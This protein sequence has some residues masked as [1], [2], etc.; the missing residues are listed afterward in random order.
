MTTPTQKK[1]LSN[2]IFLVIIIVA[3]GAVLSLGKNNF[4]VPAD[5]Q[6]NQANLSNTNQGG[7]DF[8]T[9]DLV[10]KKPTKKL[11]Y[12]I[13]D[14]NFVDI[15]SY[16]FKLAKSSKIFTDRDEKEKIRSLTNL[17]ATGKVL[18]LIAPPDEE[19]IGDLY[20]LDT[21]GS[22]QK[23]KL[24]DN[25]AS[26]Q[27]A[28]ISPDGQKIAYLL[29][30]NS[31]SDFGFKL[32]IADLGGSNKKQ[33]M[34]DSA[35]LLLYCWSPDSKKVIYSKGQ[36]LEVYS[37]DINSLKEEKVYSPNNEQI[38]ALNY[39]PS[40]EIVISK[41]PRGNNTFNQ[42]EI[43]LLDK[44][45][46]LGQLSSNNQ[47]YDTYPFFDDQGNLAYLS[48]N[49]STEN[50]DALYQLGK[51]QLWNDGQSQEITSANQVIGWRD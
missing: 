17:T 43:F 11:I 26:P 4:T 27:P 5:Q 8:T 14:K 44:N 42:A 40:Q 47:L 20:L 37:L 33:L 28:I 22:G 45:K 24:W 31:E 34:S 32:I 50:A 36:N 30:S 48:S 25:F 23:T 46:N 41:G 29:F 39:T 12:A 10:Q 3:I 2:L 18:A 7:G 51:I 9:Q 16:D 15:Y 6:N 35:N 21:D 13:K 1:N 19:F 49:Y 38:Y